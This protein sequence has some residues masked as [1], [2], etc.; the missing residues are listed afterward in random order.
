M[1]TCFSRKQ[2][3]SEEEDGPQRSYRR[4]GVARRWRHAK[5]GLNFSLQRSEPVLK[6]TGEEKLGRLV[7]RLHR[8][9]DGAKIDHQ[10][11]AGEPEGGHL[12]SCAEEAGFACG[13]TLEWNEQSAGFAHLRLSQAGETR[14]SG[15][16]SRGQPRWSWAA[17]S[18][19]RARLSGCGRGKRGAIRSIEGGG[20]GESTPGATAAL[21]APSSDL[22][23][24]LLW[25]RPAD[26][27]TD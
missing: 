11:A 26:K 27:V 15:L 4:H 2:W 17:S 23:W 6:R 18:A 22:L 14:V 12:R 7:L 10:A 25:Q 21:T 13:V 1:Q 5:N 16:S 9:A 24:R 19:M 3:G 20:E 8:I